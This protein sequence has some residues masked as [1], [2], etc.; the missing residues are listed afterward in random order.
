MRL[1]TPMLF[2][3]SSLLIFNAEAQ[4][5]N[6]EKSRKEAKPGFQGHIDLNLMLTRNTR[7]IFETGTTAHLQYTSGR[8]TLLALNNLGFMRVEGE[9][10]INN[11]FQHLRY[12]YKIG[13]GFTT[14]EFFTQHQYNSIRLLQRRFLVGGGP[15]FRIFESENTGVYIAPLVMYEQ[16]LLNDG[17]PRTDRFKGDLYVSFTYSIDERIT[18]SHTTYYQPDFA[19]LSEYRIS[20]ET[21]MEMQFLAN[22][23]FL[24]TYNLAFD[25]HP[26]ADI[27]ELFYTLRN[28]IKYNF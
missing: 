7:Q 4:L 17:S 20:S 22:F 9:N 18:F 2:V 26:P 14:A 23:S 21:G 16:E 28:G 25:S 5:V 13:N 8:N 19:L 11:G 10:L 15:R 27:P 3:L 24:V 1:F 12:N 6:I